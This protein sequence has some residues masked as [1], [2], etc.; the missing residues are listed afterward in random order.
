MMLLLVA[1]SAEAFR[2]FSARKRKLF[3]VRSH[4]RH[5]VGHHLVRLGTFRAPMRKRTAVRSNVMFFL[6]DSAAKALRARRTLKGTIDAV[7]FGLMRHQLR[8]VSEPQCPEQESRMGQQANG[9]A[10]TDCRSKRQ[11][12][13]SIA[14]ASAREPTPMPTPTPTSSPASRSIDTTIRAAAEQGAQQGS[15]HP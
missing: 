15:H 4:M 14:R 13:S 5:Q 7:H 10:S 3:G 1:L 6:I 8:L 9:P 11:Q 2:A 12:P